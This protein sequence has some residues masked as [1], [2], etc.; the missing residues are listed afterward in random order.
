MFV[1]N[2]LKAYD[3]RFTDGNSSKRS[4]ICVNRFTA[5]G[6]TVESLSDIK[7][8]MGFRINAFASILSFNSP[9]ALFVISLKFMNGVDVVK[10]SAVVVTIRHSSR[11]KSE[12]CPP[13]DGAGG[14][15][16]I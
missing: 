11:L 4:H 1:T 6:K 13:T 9:S 16:S 15:G 12:L 14:R 3:K 10:S 5:N 8:V 2:K 7:R